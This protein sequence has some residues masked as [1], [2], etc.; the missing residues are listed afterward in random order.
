M[1]SN[2]KGNLKFSPLQSTYAIKFLS[3]FNITTTQLSTIYYFEN[4][5]LFQKS[6]AALAIAKHL[7]FPYSLIG[8]FS[9]LPTGFRNFFYDFIAR[10]RYLFFGE[11]NTCRVATAKEK[12]RF[13][14]D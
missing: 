4:G 8:Y 3:K 9:F 13:L 11:R 1:R 7:S 12:T 2:N 6:D 5:Q 10:N 14:E